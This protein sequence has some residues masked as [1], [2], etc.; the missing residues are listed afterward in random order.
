MGPTSAPT[1]EPTTQPP[2]NVPTLAPTDAPTPEPVVCLGNINCNC[3]DD[4]DLSPSPCT[5]TEAIECCEATHT[6]TSA[7]TCDTI[8]YITEISAYDTGASKVVRFI[9]LRA[10]RECAYGQM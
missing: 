1:N 8:P 2:T 5:C 3:A 6:P 10:E 9:E 4:C 7:P